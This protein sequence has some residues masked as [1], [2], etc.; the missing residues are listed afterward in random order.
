MLN[1]SA[2]KHISTRFVTGLLL[3][4]IPVGVFATHN[5]AGEIRLRQIGPLTLEATIVT[6]TKASS[7]AADRDTLT[8]CWGD[9]SCMSVVRVN[10]PNGKGEIL[11]NYDNIKYNEYV[12][13]HTYAGPSRYTISMTDPNR[14]AGILNVNPPSSDNVPFYIETVYDFQNQFFGAQNSTPILQEPP[15]DIACLGKPFKHNPNAVDPDD[16]SLTYE[17]ITPLQGPGTPVPNYSFPNQIVPGPNNLLQINRLTGDI[18]WVSPQKAGEYNLAFIVVSWRNGVPIDTTVRDMQISVEDN[19]N[20]NPPEVDA[21]DEICVVA[22]Q[23]VSFPVSADDPDTLNYVLLSGNGVPF[24][25]PYSPASFTVPLV[26]TLPVVNGVFEWQTTC[27]HIARFPYGVTFKARDSVNQSTPKLSDLKKVQIKVVGPAPEDLQAQAQLGIVDLSWEKPY[28]CENAAENYFFGFS[29]WRREGSNPFVPDT[30]DPGLNGKGYTQLTFFTNT[31]Q[32]GRYVFRDTSVERGRTYCYRVLAVFARTSAGGFRFNFVESLASD[33][34]CVQLPRD[35]PLITKASVEQ[36]AATDGK[37]LVCFARPVATDLDT[38]INHGPY[39]FQLL[40]GNGFGPGN[41]Q[42][43]PGASITAN[44]FWQIPDTCFIDGGLNTIG[45]PFHYKIDF[46]VRGEQTPL[47]ST[48]DASSLF[49]SIL[50]T[51]Q[52]NVLSWQY[53]T[54]WENYR[55]DIYRFNPALGDFSLIGSTTE[56]SYIDKGLEN[57]KEY[58]YYVKSVGT[59]SIDGINDPIYNNSQELCGIPLDTVPPCPP[60]LMVDNICQDGG[61]SAVPP[62]QNDLAWTNPNLLCGGADDAVAYRIWYTPQKDLPLE[63]IN[64]L[65]GANNTN[66]QHQPE[67]GLAGCYAVSA[68]DSLGNESPLSDTVCVDNCPMYDLPNAFT[69]NG[70]GQNDVFTPFPGWRFVERV[71]MQIFNRWGNLVFE[72]QDPMINWRGLNKQGKA[73]ADG[74][75]FYICKVFER[76]VEGLVLRPEILNGFIELFGTGR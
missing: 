25:T 3:W 36:T 76:R 15:I 49:L 23:K 47:G 38:V 10:G 31:M 40:R 63:P 52:S 72:T 2:M 55:F 28:V 16:D 33:E 8:I 59:Y 66:F 42:P 26:Y 22:G 35:L 44:E 17:F 61:G 1:F 74:T 6:W 43:I 70:D 30:C 29:V 13:I 45:G 73:L 20:N 60:V 4:M 5:R 14:I 11:A 34:V 57:G 51:D 67:V 53:R 7:V 12:A 69:P 50:S 64:I 62:F 32:N 37:L 24:T 75:Y 68:I 21:I 41:L 71:E 58:C 54:P 27:E 46:F 39:R 65:Y 9:G 18:L 48:N 19:C 56:Q